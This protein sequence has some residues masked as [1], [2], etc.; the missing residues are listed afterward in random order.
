MNKSRQWVYLLGGVV[1]VGLM[2]VGLWSRSTLARKE[3][4]VNEG[5]RLKEEV[6]ADGVSEEEIR[7]VEEKIQEGDYLSAKNMLKAMMERVTSQ[8][9][10]ERLE[11]LLQRVNFAI[12]TNPIPVEGKTVE[13][14]V[15]P[16]DTLYGIAKKFGTTVE[17][18]KMRNHLRSDVIRPGQKLSIYTGKF[19]IVVD[20]SQNLLMLYADGELVKTYKVSTGKD[21]LT[22]EGEFKIVTKLKNPTFFHE[23]KAIP[24]GD[25]KNILGTRWLGFD[26][27]N[28]SYGIHGT[29]SP[30]TIGT[31]ETNGC[32][33][34]KNED[35]EEL[36]ALVPVGT[37]VKIVR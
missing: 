12:L 6:P 7:K 27:G 5:V 26:Y 18:I 33:R 11:H 15:K 30:E 19:S 20:K 13:Y 21:N 17:F 36:F 32:V 23:G 16:G 35:V 2:L 14:T 37:V 10:I 8:E 34:M 28:G 4:V 25:P 22:P 24:P 9:Q 1:L 3:K 29:T 31:Y